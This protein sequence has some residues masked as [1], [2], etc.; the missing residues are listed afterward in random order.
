MRSEARVVV[1]GGGVAGVSTLYHLTKLGWQDV[2]L[3]EEN[4]LTSGSTWH[5][6]GLCTQMIS[7]LNLL[8]LLQYSIGLYKSLEAETG[9]AVDYHQ[10]G[11]L[12]LALTEE[13]L[14]EYRNRQGIAQVLG[15]PF[16][17]IGPDQ[18]KKL[19]P[20]GNFNDALGAAHI[21]TDGYVDPTGVTH[22]LA[23]G[24]QS[25]GAEIYRH[26]S[27]EAMD[28][29]DG[30]WLIKTNKG[31]IRADV[32]VNAAGQWS[33]QLGRMVGLE[34]PIIPLEHHYL[35][36]EVLPEVKALGV[37]IPVLRDTDASFYIREECGALLVGPFERDTVAWSEHGVPENFHSSLLEPC[38]DRLEGILEQVAARVPSFAEAG[39]QSVVNGPD[40]YTPDGHC[41]MGPV[42]GLPNYH[43]LSGF[44]IFGIVFGGGAG[45]YAAEWIV[46]GQPSD[47]MWELDVRRFDDYSASSKYVVERAV[48][49]YERE[50]AIHYPE[51]EL[52]AGRPLKTGPLYDKL[53]AKGAVF[54]AR[55]AWERPLWFDKSGAHDQL[56][57]YSFR[58]GNWH[59][60]V[61]EECRAVRSSVGLLDQTSFAKYEVRGPG[62]EGFLDYLCANK[63]PKAQGSDRP[64]S[65]VHARGRHRVRHHGDE[66]RNQSLLPRLRSSHRTP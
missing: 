56:D 21:K 35:I 43:V 18:L 2:V 31:D 23:K 30:H 11:S 33:R 22:A 44:S 3:V 16:D 8:K 40:G 38:F 59:D 42:P 49:V 55:F 66:A 19:W 41:L 58:R 46:E 51:E 63:L 47:N 25:G 60:A 64:D 36:T 24:A 9:Q 34:L 7:S 5:A 15:V 4:E 48:E 37:E 45:K 10:C 57:Q 28:H 32:V 26:T 53:K 1:I 6:A 65:D 13:R 62:A 20:L 12:R 27:V 29:V 50:Y 17:I 52:P 61:G 14:D 39:I 54:G